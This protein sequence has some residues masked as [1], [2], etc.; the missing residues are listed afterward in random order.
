[1]PDSLS[2]AKDALGRGEPA[3]ALVHLWSA[4]DA[5]QAEQNAGDLA[6]VERMAETIAAK[7][8]EADA[9]EAERLL[10][11]IDRAA[12]ED[13]AE[14]VTVEPGSFEPP[15]VPAETSEPEDAEPRP[16]SKGARLWRLIPFALFLFFI[17]RDVWR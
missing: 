15:P 16:A 13:A 7:G 8:D 9:A 17:L 6:A 12:G 2:H 11:E 1:V 5:A 10:R 4:L 3:E 14:T